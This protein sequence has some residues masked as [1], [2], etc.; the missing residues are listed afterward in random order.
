[1]DAAPDGSDPM[2]VL[3]FAPGSASLLVHWLLI[4]FDEPHA[5]RRLDLEAR[6]Q[7]RDDYLAL[8][9][10][11]VVPTLVVDGTPM[12]EAA[13]I[14]LWLAA[15][16]PEAGLL[17]EP[18]TPAHAAHLQWMFHLANAVQPLLRQWWYPQ[19]AAGADLA[20][21]ARAAVEPRIEAA[22]TR[23]DAHLAAH[24]PH[25]LGGHPSVAD[26]FLVMLMRWSR[27]TARPAHDWPALGALAARLKA[28]PSF[29]ELYRREGL[30][31]WA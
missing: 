7:K 4:E 9:P 19:E 26:F 28:R 29:R 17:P 22:W 12:T 31:E 13:A 10:A 1:M 5:L 2:H 14:A 8:N 20:D 18:G 24:G 3:Y 23:I 25:L 11:G 6:D 15:R 27:K 16:H 30:E 21:R